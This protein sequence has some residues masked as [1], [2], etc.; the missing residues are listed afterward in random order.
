MTASGREMEWWLSGPRA[1]RRRWAISRSR[2]LVLAGALY[3]AVPALGTAQVVSDTE[4]QTLVR[5]RVDRGGR[6][7]EVDALLRS[8]EAAGRT[9]PVEPLTNKIRE[10]LA[11]GADPQRIEDVL[12]RMVASLG[13]ADA[14]VREL[15]PAATGPDR[16]AAV[17]LLAESL[18]AGVTVEEIRELGRELA[19]MPTAPPDRLASS[20]KGL[21]LIKEARLPAAD[22]RQVMTEAARRGFRST[23]LLDLG[24]EIKRR[25]RDFQTGRASLRAVRDAIA[26][27]ER[28]EQLFRDTRPEPVTRPAATAPERPQPMRPEATRPERPPVPERPA[29]TERPGR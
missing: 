7:E 26:R 4:R 9:V 22:G 2:T 24:R 15:T 5:L 27:G 6:A 14:L 20:A 21:G 28:P 12:R 25:E 10:G 23:E 11:K 3:V 17:V 1:S 13:A 18:D 8:A 19:T 29:P 16:R